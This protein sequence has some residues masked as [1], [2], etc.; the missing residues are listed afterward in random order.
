FG[1]LSDRDRRRSEV[2]G[3]ALARQDGDLRVGREE[4][5]EEPVSLLDAV[6]VVRNRLARLD[7]SILRGGLVRR[8]STREPGRIELHLVARVRGGDR[9]DVAEDA[10][11]AGLAGRA[12]A[13]VLR[14]VEP[15]ERAGGGDRGDGDHGDDDES[16]FHEDTLAKVGA[17][18]GPKDTG[19]PRLNPGAAASRFPGRGRRGRHG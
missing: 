17:R 16:G 13:W 14:E 15:G 8:D 2:R 3:I 9:V 1:E 6:V 7:G 11:V 10:L 19:D 4:I 18:R 5:R 12:A